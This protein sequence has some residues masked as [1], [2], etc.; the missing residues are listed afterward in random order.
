MSV[1]LPFSP[2]D[3]I[4][5]RHAGDLRVSS[6]ATEA[7]AEAIQAEGAALAT[8]AAEAATADDRKTLMVEDFEEIEAVPDRS[9]VT[10]PIAPVDRIARLDIDDRYRVS[11]DARV[12]LAAT[13]EAWAGDV[14]EG[15]ATL[16]R[17]AGRRTVQA[18]DVETYLH[19]RG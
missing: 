1:E 12:A 7:L 16:A 11:M 18:E 10:L 17:H 14:A 6:S 4:I 9:S 2:V 19:L 5:R 15:A 13:L 8:A 3:A